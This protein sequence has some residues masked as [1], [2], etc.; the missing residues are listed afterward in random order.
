MIKA[1]PEPAL[2]P[3]FPLDGIGEHLIDHRFAFTEMNCH[4]GATPGA[5]SVAK[6][7]RMPAPMHKRLG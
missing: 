4:L 1:W 6:I 3:A 2:M 5:G 7:I